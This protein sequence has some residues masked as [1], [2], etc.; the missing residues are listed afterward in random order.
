MITK[1]FTL[2]ASTPARFLVVAFA[3]LFAVA[4]AQA[5]EKVIWT[6][7]PTQGYESRS[8]LTLD[9]AGNLYG[10]T[11]SGGVNNCGN[12]FELSPGSGGKWTETIIYSFKGCQFPAPSPSGTM[13]F[14]KAGNLYGAAQ[15]DF[16]SSGVI[17][18]LTKGANGTW[19]YSLVHNFTT[20][21]GS[22]NG[23]LTWDSDSNL[24]GTTSFDSTTFQGIAFELSPQPN[25]SWK[26]TVLFTFPASNGVGF[27]AAG[28]VF[29]NQGN[30]YGPAY[31]GI[32]G[33]GGYGAIY[34]LSPQTSGPWKLTVIRNFTENSGAQFPS[35]RLTFDSSGNLYGASNQANDGQV[36][37]LSPSSSGEWKL[38]IIHAFTSGGDGR[39]PVGALVFDASGNLYGATS[40]GGSGCNR[41]LCGTI[42]KLTPQSRVTWQETILHPFESA[43]DGSEPQQGPALDSSG[44]LYGTT[45]YGGS[46]YGYGTVYEITP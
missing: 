36:F 18:K 12:A 23:D 14:D 46:R 21:E 33:S 19:S 6:F 32:G 37:E 16:G 30:L 39:F 40:S 25:S 41:S 4:G 45:Y 11:P 43:S 31:F 24:Y 1:S 28:V 27:P 22:P 9:S 38:T 29:D 15:G 13:V 42:Y 2:L 5:G 8:G 3:L 26:E 44:N 35:S 17:F 20:S 34:E 7:D 10:T